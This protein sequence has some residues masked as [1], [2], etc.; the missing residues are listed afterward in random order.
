MKER[1][2]EML[3][4]REFLLALFCAT[5]L[6]MSLEVDIGTANGEA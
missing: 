1:K 6:L 3:G 5:R 4:V 2:K